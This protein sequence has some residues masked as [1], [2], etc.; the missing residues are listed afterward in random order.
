MFRKKIK[1]YHFKSIKKLPV[2]SVSY[3]AYAIYL[4]KKS[5]TYFWSY[6]LN[7]KMRNIFQRKIQG[8][9]SVLV[10]SNPYFVYRGGTTYDNIKEFC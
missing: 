3:I 6:F 8:T 4:C 7:L 5:N 9:S 10:N 1:E 2:K